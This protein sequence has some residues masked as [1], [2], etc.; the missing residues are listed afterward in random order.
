MVEA[1]KHWKFCLKQ[2]F[3]MGT[4]PFND[5]DRHTSDAVNGHYQ[6]KNDWESEAKTGKFLFLNKEKIAAQ[7]KVISF[8]LSKIGSNIISGKSI[9][10]ISLPIDIFETRSN[11]E[12]FAHSFSFA[13]IFLQRA[14]ASSDP[15]E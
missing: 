5:D 9:T 11:L 15:I 12:R 6:F 3:A 10:S 8:I 4:A 2:R 7:K 1:N 13:P 14:G